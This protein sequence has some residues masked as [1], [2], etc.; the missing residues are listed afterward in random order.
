MS[1]GQQDTLHDRIFVQILVLG[2]LEASADTKTLCDDVIEAA[3]CLLSVRVRGD[4]QRMN[5]FSR[6]LDG[7]DTILAAQII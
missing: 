1:P 3:K 2:C 5:K 4:E 6:Y 7:L